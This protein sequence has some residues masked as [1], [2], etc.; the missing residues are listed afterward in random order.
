MGDHSSTCDP[1]ALHKKRVTAVDLQRIEKEEQEG[2]R[3]VTI[4]SSNPSALL[5]KRGRRTN[6]QILQSRV[7]EPS[8]GCLQLVSLGAANKSTTID[9]WYNASDSESC[10]TRR[11][12]DNK[13]D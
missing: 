5:R 6:N 7:H 9:C 4:N 1:S 13:P 12:M 3:K 10:V 8:S 2:T 11:Y